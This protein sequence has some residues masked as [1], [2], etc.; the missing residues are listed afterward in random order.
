MTKDDSR[1]NRLWIVFS[2]LVDVIEVTAC[3]LFEQKFSDIQKQATLW[4]Q[5]SQIPE[6]LKS[7]F[8]NT[9]GSDANNGD[10]EMHQLEQARALYLSRFLQF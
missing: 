6:N 8:L 2:G 4:E 1:C 5:I 7:N 3:V 9:V 10:D